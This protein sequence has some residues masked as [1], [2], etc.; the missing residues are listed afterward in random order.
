MRAMVFMIIACLVPVC[1]CAS[2]MI[3]VVV[4]CAIASVRG[5][6]AC[7]PQRKLES[8]RLICCESKPWYTRFAR[9]IPIRLCILLFM[10][11]IGEASHPGPSSRGSN[12]VLGT[13]N[14]TGLNN[15][16]HLVEKNMNYGDLWLVAETHLTTRSLHSFRCGLRMAESNFQYVIGDFPVPGRHDKTLSGSYRGVATASLLATLGQTPFTSRVVFRCVLL[17][18]ATCGSLLVSCMVSPRATCIRSTWSTMTSCC[19]LLL[20]KCVSNIRALVLL[21]VTS[22][23]LKVSLTHKTCFAEQGL[24]TFKHWHGSDGAYIPN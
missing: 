17:C 19:D 11:R 2:M 9:V 4:A 12:F 15:K 23:P 21:E 5:L 8:Q 24:R 6:S 22:M 14:P 7:V 1:P 3:V 18:W 13:F 16:A 10:V 20:M